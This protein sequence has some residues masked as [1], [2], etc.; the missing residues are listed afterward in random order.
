MADQGEAQTW[1]TPAQL[2]AVEPP[3]SASDATV[4][5]VTGTQPWQVNDQWA[6][7]FGI[8]T[9][10]LCLKVQ[11]VFYDADA[12]VLRHTVIVDYSNQP[13]VTRHVPTPDELA[14]LE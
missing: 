3:P 9:D 13:C 7:D 14:R 1:P 4:R 8:S 6:Y 12:D 10:R 5:V 2:N 11:H